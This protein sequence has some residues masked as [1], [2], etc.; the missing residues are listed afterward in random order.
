[1]DGWIKLHRQTMDSS[2]WVKPDIFFVWTWCLLKAGHKE[3]KYPFN[4]NDI[5]LKPGE[6]ITGRDKAVSEL[7]GITAQKW[8]SA[9]NYLKSTNRIEVKTTNKFSIICIKKWSKYQLLTNKQPTNNQQITT[10]K[11]EKNDNK[12]RLKPKKFS[13]GDDTMGKSTKQVIAER[14]G[15]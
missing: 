10:N 1:M 13:T 12:Y 7:P 6:F 3:K 14:Y 11:N 2:I 9:I 5:L 15:N 4:G 8:R